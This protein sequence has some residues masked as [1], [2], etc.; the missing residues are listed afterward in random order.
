MEDSFN[1]SYEYWEVIFSLN[2]LLDLFEIYYQINLF[3][4]NA[5]K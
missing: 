1:N 4:N 2:N 5:K 3:N